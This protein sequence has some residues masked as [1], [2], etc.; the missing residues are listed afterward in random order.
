VCYNRLERTTKNAKTGHRFVTAEDQL[1]L[2]HGEAR[3]S[4]VEMKYSRYA[5]FLPMQPVTMA[6]VREHFPGEFRRYSVALGKATVD[7][8][9]AHPQEVA[10]MAEQADAHGVITREQFMLTTHASPRQLDEVIREGAVQGLG[11]AKKR[12]QERKEDPLGMAPDDDCYS[13]Q[14]ISRHPTQ[15]GSARDT[16]GARGLARP[17]SS[18]QGREGGGEL[19]GTSRTLGYLATSP[20]T[21]ATTKLFY[22]IRVSM[23]KI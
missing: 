1:V 9:E 20:K 18:R 21:T 7:E 11:G 23:S 4:V 13:K 22:S 19:A 12:S 10:Q 14:C 5:H 17:R 15:K 8:I 16:G 3:V 6:E 2:N